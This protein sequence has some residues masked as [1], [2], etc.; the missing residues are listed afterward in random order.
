MRKQ[1]INKLIN[2]S[3]LLGGLILCLALADLF[4]RLFP[5]YG[6]RY[7]FSQ[8][9]MENNPTDRA[10][11]RNRDYR[12]H[13]PSSILGYELVPNSVPE[14]NS[15]GMVGREHRLEKDKDTYRILVLGDSITEHNWY[16]E[17]LEDKLNNSNPKLDHKFELWNGAVMGYQVNQYAAY[18]KHKGLRYRPDMVIIGFCLND[19]DTQYWV[20]YKDKKGFTIFY[21]PARKLSKILPLNTFLFKHSYL[22]RFLFLRIENLLSNPK[23]KFP[24]PK[25]EG[26]YYLK[27]IKNICQ[28]KKIPLLGVIFP[29]LKRLDEYRDD[30]MDR[31]KEMIEVLDILNIEYID[32]H[33]YLPEKDRYALRRDRNDY[34]HP[35]I[36][37]HEIAANII[38][39]Y[40]RESYFKNR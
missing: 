25:T 13:R 34:S 26:L 32:L 28:E 17:K 11:N 18:L 31:Y 33:K 3:L 9:V 39:N 6:F 19:F 36:E 5:A 24:E 4:F 10:M 38:Y 29:Y 23:E 16:V 37:G 14:V 7:N 2:L 40:L 20:F 12:K 22:Y 35:S 15:F 30:E 1:H 8:F 21:N 27:T